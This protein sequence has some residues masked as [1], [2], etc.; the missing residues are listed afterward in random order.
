MIPLRIAPA[1]RCGLK[2]PLRMVDNMVL[3]LPTPTRR[4]FLTS[5]AALTASALLP[6]SG[7]R[8]A[9]AASVNEF[10]LKAA[11][12]RTH[13][14]PEPYGETPVWAYNDAVPGPEIRVRQGDRLRAV[15]ENGR[16]E[17]TAVHWHGVRSFRVLSRNGQPTAHREW[18]DTVLM[19]PRDKVEIAFVAD[20]PGDWM[21]H[22]HILEL[23][24]AGMM[25]AIRVSGKEERI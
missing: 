11:P 23:Q 17:E 19:A 2:R 6:V 24:A 18:Q 16:D 7:L 20:N 8:N 1:A 12:G 4:A 14:V 10:R 5:A 13:L 3:Y 15:V 9:R 21:F 22:C 25:G